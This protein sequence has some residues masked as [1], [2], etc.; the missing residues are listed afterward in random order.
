MAKKPADKLAEIL[1]QETAGEES[2]ENIDPSTLSPEE[3]MIVDP[4]TGEEIPKEA[5][6]AGEALS[7]EEKA[8]IEAEAIEAEKVVAAE[9]EASKKLEE[10]ET[11]RLESIVKEEQEK[12][13]LV[14]GTI[15]GM[16]SEI[17]EMQTAE[18]STEEEIKN[19]YE[20][21]ISEENIPPVILEGKPF[22]VIEGKYVPVEQAQLIFQKRK[23]LREFKKFQILMAKSLK[24]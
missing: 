12:I 22:Q 23:V 11:A 19:E 8:K 18:I 10:E 13:D 21:T 7:E 6:E 15:D 1:A 17:A 4:V 16:M 9:A 24:K 2:A 3:V 5:L 14:K 20:L